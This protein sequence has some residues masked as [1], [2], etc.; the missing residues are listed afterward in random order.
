LRNILDD[1]P[2]P[3]PLEVPELI[4]SDGSNR[5]KTYRELLKQHQEDSRCSVCHHSIDPLGFAFQNFD[6]S[7]RWREVEYERYVMND[8]DGKIEWR[9]EGKA[10]PVDTVGKLPRGEEFETFAE[11][12]NRLVENYTDDFAKGL[13]KNLVLYGTG[14][15]PDIADRK[16]LRQILAA[17]K[18]EDYRFKDM[19][20]ALI[21]SEIFLGPKSR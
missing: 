1:P 19:I 10:R 13:L 3:P 6:L 8:L 21:R 2:P 11:F 20:K 5:G 18:R 17:H 16:I 4:P 12:K 7:G 15:K 9:G 14:R